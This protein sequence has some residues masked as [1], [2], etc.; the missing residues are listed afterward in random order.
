MFRLY[1]MKKV[2]KKKIGQNT[3][4]LKVAASHHMG[5][6]GGGGEIETPNPKT[7]QTPNPTP[8]GYRYRVGT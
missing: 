8:G 5:V 2:N 6:G 7:N 3:I 4:N 1:K